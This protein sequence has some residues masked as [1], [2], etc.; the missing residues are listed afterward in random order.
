MKKEN[1]DVIIERLQKINWD[2]SDFNSSKYPYDLNSIP[3]YP[4]TFI[5]P[6]PRLLVASL[7]N[8]KDIVLDPFGGKGTTAM[9]TLL[10]DRIPLYCD[11]N[12]FIS[13]NTEGLFAAIEYVL[14]KEVE[15]ENEEEKIHSIIVTQNE[16]EIVL[17]EYHID[18]EVYKWFHKNTVCSL[19]SIVK[20]IHIS[21]NESSKRIELI[22][23]LAFSSILK[24]ASSQTG[25]FT[26]VTD[27]CKPS[28]LK[29]K[30]AIQ[31]YLE[32]IRQIIKAAQEF[33]DQYELSFPY[34]DLRIGLNKRKI[35]TG[36]AKDLDWIPNDSVDLV[37]TS[38][39]YLCS[40]DYIK[41]MR[42]MNMFFDNS[43]A[44]YIDV[45]QEIG[46]RAQR[47]G[48]SEIVV[49][50]FYYDMEIVFRNINRVL[51]KD[52]FFAL[53]VGQGKSKITSGYDI[54][55]DLK[56][57]L[58]NNYCFKLVFEKERQIGNRVI[59]VGGVDKESILIFQNKG[60]TQV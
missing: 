55:T 53:V 58:I 3:W 7:S 42:L 59:Q 21:E 19:L 51:K 10:Q 22:R 40:Q 33:I 25:H 46:A 39:P 35:I 9:E 18:S 17:K 6:I 2:F 37:V 29:E 12:P 13:E 43:H 60:E 30:D 54:V 34:S 23:K 47:R 45:K 5:S 4:A 1:I 56:N 20:L 28:T 36:N 44:F 16:A 14:Y 8:Q 57:I 11:L 24:S 26:Y 38:P 32:K 49:P 31:L 15:L 50:K 52:K 41:T 48:K 27:N